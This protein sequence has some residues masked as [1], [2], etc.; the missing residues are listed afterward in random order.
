M[1]GRRTD[2][3]RRTTE[4]AYT[5]SSPGAFGSGE[6]K[7]MLSLFKQYELCHRKRCHIA[8]VNSEDSDQPVHLQSVILVNLI[9]SC[10]TNNLINLWILRNLYTKN[11]V[12]Q[13]AFK[14]VHADQGLQCDNY[15]YTHSMTSFLLKVKG[16]NSVG[17]IFA[18]LLIFINS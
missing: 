18:S 2:D 14:N 8:C 5:I 3:G 1:D 12:F 4:P 10:L 16:S 6:L 9:L 13:S 15:T 7:T 11:Q 17:F